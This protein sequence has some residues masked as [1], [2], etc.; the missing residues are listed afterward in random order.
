MKSNIL[1]L[2]ASL[3]A[4]TLFSSELPQ[5][6]LRLSPDESGKAISPH[7]MGVF[8]E[9]INYA[10]DGGLYAELIRNRSFEMTAREQADWNALSF[11]SLDTEGEGKAYLNIDGSRPIHPNNPHYVIFGVDNPDGKVALVNHG[12]DGIPVVKGEELR[13]SLFARHLYTGFRWRPHDRDE[14]PIGLLA[15]LVARD[16]EVIAETKLDKPTWEWTHITATLKADREEPLAHFELIGLDEGGV[17]LDMISLF[18]EKTYKGRPNGLRVDLAETIA[19]LQPKFMRFP[20]GCLVHGNGLPNA[21]KWK[22]TVGPQE[23]RK[24]QAN[25]WGYHQEVGLGYYEY[26]QFCEDMGAEPLPVVPAGVS[27]QNSGFTGGEGQDCVPMQDMADYIQ[28][29][30]DLIEWANGPADSTWG[31]VRAAAGHPEPFGLKFLGV[32]N[33]D[34]ITEGFETRFKLLEAA[35]REEYPEITIIGTVGPFWEGEDFDK[36]WKLA[37]EMDLSMVDEHYYM[38]PQW[39]LDNMER[40]DSYDRDESAVYLGEYAAH[41]V[42]RKSTLRSAIAE[43]AYLTHVERNGDIVQMVS[44]APMLANLQHT[45]WVPDLIYFDRHEVYPTIN[46][47]VQ[48][49]FSN[50]SGDIYLPMELVGDAS[51]IAW[52]AVK[53]SECGT[54]YI[55][56][57]NP[58]EEAVSVSLDLGKIPS[59]LKSLLLT[60]DPMAENTSESPDTV[61][62]QEQQLKAK[63]GALTLELPPCSLRLIV[64]P[65]KG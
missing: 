27:C 19:A 44:Y 11:W 34:R 3:G 7:L 61:E 26:F 8:F 18:P 63:K 2:C 28:D 37:R 13:L 48:K 38:P 9:D 35:I 55:K 65:A 5:T 15:R 64:L 39:F 24:G 56:L 14:E 6:Q 29:V 54:T 22:D 16:G 59:K 33:E 57:V 50:Y 62:V 46:Y 21:Y 30:L 60:G 51:G 25:L 52:S 47:E 45:Q 41:D 20:G 31:A 23:E 43:A 32:G 17:G 4:S 10:A 42:D 53:N 1:M 36:G 40:Y 12:F 58:G 49:I